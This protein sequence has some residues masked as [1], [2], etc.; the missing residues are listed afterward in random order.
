MA[1]ETIFTNL[2][3]ALLHLTQL[4][5][6]GSPLKTMKNAYFTSKAVLNFKIFKFL[7]WLFG[8]LAKRLEQKDKLNILRSKGN[9][10][11]KLGQLIEYNI[12]NLVVEKSYI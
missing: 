3:G 2:K 12:R 10:T 1:Y 8:H 7:S 6:I 5:P 9:Q 4:L 11:I